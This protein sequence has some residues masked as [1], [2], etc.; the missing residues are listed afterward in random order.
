MNNLP[1]DKRNKGSIRHSWVSSEKRNER[2]DIFRCQNSKRIGH[3]T[4]DGKFF[5]S[6][7]L[8][9]K[10]YNCVTV[11]KFQLLLIPSGTYKN[12]ENEVFIDVGFD[13]NGTNHLDAHVGY[14]KKPS[15]NGYTYIPQFH[16]TINSERVAA[17]SGVFSHTSNQKR[18][19]R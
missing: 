18:Q 4:L 12:T 8:V 7:W 5:N 2:Y 11:R 3:V 10:K 14:V 15:N 17:I 13:V 16:L 19:H 1:D 9:F 6:Q